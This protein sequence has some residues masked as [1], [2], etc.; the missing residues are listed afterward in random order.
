MGT[1]FAASRVIAISLNCDDTDGTTWLLLVSGSNSS[2]AVSGFF[3]TEATNYNHPHT[4]YA[5][6]K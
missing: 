5:T 4:T 6:E 1:K 3:N 2:N